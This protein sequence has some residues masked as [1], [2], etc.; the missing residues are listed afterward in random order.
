MKG[1]T[2]A[3]QDCESESGTLVEITSQSIYELIAKLFEDNPVLS[4]KYEF[5]H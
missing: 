1:W 4:D 5:T 3:Q 2:S